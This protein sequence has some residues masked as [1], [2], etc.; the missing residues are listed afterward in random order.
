MCPSAKSAALSE[1]SMLFLWPP[2]ERAKISLAWIKYA[3]R[4]RRLDEEPIA[5]DPIVTPLLGAVP[6]F[7]P[8]NVY[9]G[10]EVVAFDAIFSTVRK[11]RLVQRRPLG[12]TL[13][14]L[15]MVGGG[16]RH[17]APLPP[18]HHTTC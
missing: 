7:I 2:S 6:D 10:D 9:G 18:Q 15:A 5:F 13:S 4:R 14:R 11:H 17:P 3:R 12:D 8:G 16:D 1:V